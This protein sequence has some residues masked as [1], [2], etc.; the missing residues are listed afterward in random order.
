[1]L[2]MHDKVRKPRFVSNLG[3]GFL[4]SIF[5]SFENGLPCFLIFSHPWPLL[6]TWFLLVIALAGPVQTFFYS[7]SGII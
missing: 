7:I 3:R 5:R 4:V 2:E 1:M 6:V